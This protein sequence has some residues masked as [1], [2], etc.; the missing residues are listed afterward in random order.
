LQPGDHDLTQI[1]LSELRGSYCVV[2]EKLDGAN[3]GIS[4]GD[5][6]RIRLQSRGHVL[7][8]GAREKHWDL[9]KQWAHTHEAA[10]AARIPAGAIDRAGGRAAPRRRQTIDHAAR[11]RQA[12]LARSLAA[13]R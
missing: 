3:A 4:V 11:E 8:G 10:L 7:V 2:E 9:F 5:D 13:R 1:P 12:D 6:G